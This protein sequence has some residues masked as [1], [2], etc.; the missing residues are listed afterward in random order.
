MK[1]TKNT[2]SRVVRRKSKGK[3]RKRIVLTFIFLIAPILIYGTYLYVKADSALS[4]AYEDNGRDKSVLR[5][6]IVDPDF[7]NVS[8]L[9]MGVDANEKRDNAANART[10]ALMLATLNKDEKSVKMLSIPR[11]SYVYI[12]EVNYEDKINHAHAYGGTTATID[13]VEHLLDIPVDYYIKVNFEAFVQVVDAINGID[14]EVPYEFKESN[15]QDKRDAIH[16]LAGE[17]TLDGE[18]AL[19][20][21]RTRKMDNDIERG[22][23]QLE[24]VKAAMKKATSISSILKYDNIID[25][26]GDNMATNMTFSEIKSFI[27]YAT[28]GKGLDIDSFS[29]DGM[30]YQPAGTYFWKLDEPSLA[31]AKQV[32]SG[33]LELT[34]TA[35]DSE[36]GIE[37]KAD[38]AD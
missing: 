5:D 23:R 13:T 38:S 20:L 31:D 7:D 6:D 34:K 2:Q 12:P 18:E 29:L 3:W 22:K 36:T 14:I 37:Q 19:A 35:S 16:L 8:I 10:D 21:A 33:H 9:I 24:I 25:A 27:S 32:L 1:K 17:Q 11:D 30:D 4:N 28:N 26:V 15:S